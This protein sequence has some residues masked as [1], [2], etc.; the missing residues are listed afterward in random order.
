M[1]EALALL[2]GVSYLGYLLIEKRKVAIYRSSFSHV[3][4]VAGTRGKTTVT[5]MVGHALRSKGVR[6]FTKVS[7]TIP[8]YIDT[9][10]E[11]HV[12]KRLGLANIREQMRMMRRAYLEKA[13]VLVIECMAIKEEYVRLTQ[14][15]ML[16]A[17]HVVITNI[18]KDHLEDQ[19]S[20]QAHA[21]LAAVPRA[22]KLFV[23][24][25]D[26]DIFFKTANEQN[27][28]LATVE[29]DD[30]DDTFGNVAFVEAVIASLGYETD[31]LIKDYAP[32]IG[33]FGMHRQKGVTFV[34]A[35]SVN[36][37][38]SLENIYEKLKKSEDLDLAKAT[39]LINNRADRPQ[40]ALDF[41]DFL[42]VLEP[43]IVYV[44][45]PFYRRFQKALKTTDVRRY[46]S[47]ESV[48]GSLV[49]GIGNI[50]SVGYEV[51]DYFREG[52]K[53]HG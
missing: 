25:D 7:G 53:I 38:S 20:D 49:L 42:K 19:K 30:F 39:F 4:H 50:Q 21:L 28:L 8:S 26:H 35:F 10:G 48:E 6:V 41:L 22:G 2:I 17:D 44:A 32:D 5:R 1:I 43:K 46:R 33:A 45:G 36:D 3:I 14:H 12:I 31:D 18:R 29:G 11:E 23:R 24:R 13:D 37:R 40:R 16:R 27:A 9:E 15:E 34:N 47:P 51:I 52:A